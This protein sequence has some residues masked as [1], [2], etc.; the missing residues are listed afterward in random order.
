MPSIKVA[1]LE[2]PFPSHIFYVFPREHF[3]NLLPFFFI[4]KLM[5][6]NNHNK[7]IVGVWAF[8]E[9]FIDFRQM[10]FFHISVLGLKLL[11]M[12]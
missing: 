4:E 7:A 2:C 1:I 8:T 12:S 9:T 6:L 5:H 11:K 10:F 3:W